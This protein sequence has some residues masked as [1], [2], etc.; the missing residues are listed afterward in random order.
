MKYFGTVSK[1]ALLSE[2][3]LNFVDI[4]KHE[5]VIAF[6]VGDDMALAV[7][8]EISKSLKAGANVAV[9]GHE[10]EKIVVFPGKVFRFAPKEAERRQKA[11]DYAKSIGIPEPSSLF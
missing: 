3:M 8:E 6:E 7:A 10:Y 4:K 11:L 2:A 5:P 1:D 9:L